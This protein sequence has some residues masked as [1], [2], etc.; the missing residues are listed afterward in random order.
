[1]RTGGPRGRDRHPEGPTAGRA[2][3]PFGPG[4]RTAPAPRRD[5]TG[6]PRSVRSHPRRRLR[7]PEVTAALRTSWRG[8]VGMGSDGEWFRLVRCRCLN[9]RKSDTEAAPP[10]G[11]ALDADRAAVGGRDSCRGRQPEAGAR[12]AQP[13]GDVGAEE[14]AEQARPFGGADSASPVL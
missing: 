9:Y 3:D 13:A 8:R 5:A 7:L 10:V 11:F 4:G 2:A 12:H 14:R 6:A 1:G